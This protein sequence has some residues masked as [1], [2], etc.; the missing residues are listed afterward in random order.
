MNV[1]SLFDGISCARLAVNRVGLSIDKYFA[2]E[3]NKKAIAVSQRHFPDIVHLGSVFDLKTSSLP[4]I[5]VLIGGS[6]CQ[7]LS[8]MK[9][10][11]QGLDGSKSVLFWEYVRILDDVRPECFIFENVASMSN[12]SRYAITEAFCNVE[13][14]MINA[15]LVSAQNRERLFWIGKKCSDGYKQIHIPLPE[16]RHIYIVDILEN[17]FP[18]NN[19]I[20][21]KSFAITSSYGKSAI[22]KA[23][24][25]YSL[26]SNQRT[27]VYERS[28]YPLDKYA[29]TQKQHQRLL[30]LK[31]RK[32]KEGGLEYPMNVNGKSL[33]LLSEDSAFSRS[34]NVIFDGMLVRRLTPVEC[35][36]LQG[37]PDNYTANVN[38]TSRYK[39]I[40]N[41]FNVDVVAH[42]LRNLES[43]HKPDQSPMFDIIEND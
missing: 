9:K 30:K 21:N 6:P 19:T 40:G 29:V 3:I 22:S 39:L 38:Q 33:A 8:V 43:N 13:P 42:I 16:D 26:S 20:D 17:G 32:S 5:N 1:L 4:E 41:A 28:N 25:E 15:S 11:R 14:V 31:G 27:L 18:L 34:T 35:E 12:E 37:I 7:D 23:G 36:R 24:I 10:N 2:S